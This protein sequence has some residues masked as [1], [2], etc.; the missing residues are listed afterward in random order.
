M[1][2]AICDGHTKDFLISFYECEIEIL[3]TQPTK[4]SSTTAVYNYMEN[5]LERP[6]ASTLPNFFEGKVQ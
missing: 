3:P 1:H 6:A 5:F 4:K 2:F